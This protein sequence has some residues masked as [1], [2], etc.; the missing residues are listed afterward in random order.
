MEF[1]REKMSIDTCAMYSDRILESEL[2]KNIFFRVL[3][4]PRFF[5]RTTFFGGFVKTEIIFFRRRSWDRE[6]KISYEFWSVFNLDFIMRPG[7]E[8]PISGR[9]AIRKILWPGFWEALT[10][11][12][13]FF[14]DL[15]KKIVGFRKPIF[16]RKLERGIWFRLLSAERR[17][18]NTES[19]WRGFESG[20]KLFYS[21]HA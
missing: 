12:F 18:G 14:R 6:K 19:W 8:I 17:H 1:P 7:S 10:K 5:F 13:N 20:C 16:G 15:K 21:I 2:N 3:T 4:E 11:N 9:S